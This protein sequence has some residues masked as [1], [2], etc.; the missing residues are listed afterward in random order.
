MSTMLKVN[1]LAADGLVAKGARLSAV[2]VLSKFVQNIPVV[3]PQ[4]FK[5]D[6][7]H[8]FNR[9]SSLCLEAMWPQQSLQHRGIQV[10]WVNVLVCWV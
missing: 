5:C 9:Q 7:G 10:G 6:S 8:K 2:M 4:E 1:I 3:A